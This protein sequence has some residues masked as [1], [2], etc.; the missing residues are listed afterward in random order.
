MVQGPD[1]LWYTSPLHTYTDVIVSLLR[2][3][4]PTDIDFFLQSGN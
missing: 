3:L 2:G 1:D 4:Q